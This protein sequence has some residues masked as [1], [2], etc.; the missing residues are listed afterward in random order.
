MF[1]KV[2]NIIHKLCSVYL[3]SSKKTHKAIVSSMAEQ[4][5]YVTAGSCKNLLNTIMVHHLLCNLLLF[6]ENVY[7]FT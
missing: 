1:Q 7:Q 5:H 3:S 2:H 6:A 4:N